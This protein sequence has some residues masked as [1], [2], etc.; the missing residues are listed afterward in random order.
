MVY[1]YKNSILS[2]VINWHNDEQNWTY[3]VILFKMLKIQK[4]VYCPISVTE[5]KHTYIFI[6]INSW[7][8][9]VVIAIVASYILIKRKILAV[10]MTLRIIGTFF[11][12]VQYFNSSS[13]PS[14]TFRS[15]CKIMGVL[16]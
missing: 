11:K 2:K 16:K 15:V 6:F 1:V 7:C 9:I 4:Y 12:S 3:V 8:Y 14:T 13:T 5:K 10:L